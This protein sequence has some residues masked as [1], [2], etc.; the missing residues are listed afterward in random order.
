[1]KRFFNGSVHRP[2]LKDTLFKNKNFILLFTLTMFLS[3][4]VPLMLNK[5]YIFDYIGN[6]FY[7]SIMALFYVATAAILIIVPFFFFNYLTKK[8][9]VDFIHSL[10]I[11]RISFFRQ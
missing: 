5:N 9:S 8:R 10:P 2:L 4:P 1:M 7:T 3:F 6:D 11:S